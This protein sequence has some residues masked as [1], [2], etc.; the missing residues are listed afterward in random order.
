ME[1]EAGPGVEGE[2]APNVEAAGR[3]EGLLQRVGLGETETGSL[4]TSDN[5]CALDANTPKNKSLLISGVLHATLANDGGST[6]AVAACPPFSEN[7]G[8]PQVF[9][10]PWQSGVQREDLGT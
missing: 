1:S 3:L 9:R 8:L 6:A 7:R 10:P 5:A 2:P 4:L